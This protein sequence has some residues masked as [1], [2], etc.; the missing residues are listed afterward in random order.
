ML[1]I[2]IPA[3]SANLGAGYDSL[4][5]AVSLYNYMTLEES[6]RVD[7]AANDGVPIPTDESNLVYTTAKHLFDLCGRPFYGL[8]IR[9]SNNIPMARGLGSSSACIVGG[10]VGANLLLGSPMSRDEILNLAAQLEGHPDN[11]APALL[12][13]LAT[14]VLENRKVYYV[15]QSLKQDLAFAAIV[16]DFELK[17]TVA[18]QAIPKQVAHR[19]GVFNLARA[20]LMSVSLYSGNYH[21]LRIA[22][23]DQLHQP[24]RLSLI[25]GAKE[26][27]NM[28]YNNGAY[29]AYIS[30]AGSTLM[31]IVDKTNVDFARRV[32]H[33]LD[34]MGRASWQVLMLDVDNIGTTAADMPIDKLF[35]G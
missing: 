9:Q 30:G 14:A 13:G 23:Q 22:A 15:K 32:R 34:Q 2:K 5:V 28:L 18:R 16:P 11:V 27:I 20:A 25:P 31:G 4:G 29:A 8:K 7:I 1:E 33:E 6:D 35:K 17:T 12:G 10:L 19:D 21:N 3:T 26:T 24:Y